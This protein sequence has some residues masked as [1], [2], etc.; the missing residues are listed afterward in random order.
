MLHLPAGYGFSQG[1]EPA[2]RTCLHNLRA[3][4]DA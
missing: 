3:L 2:T 1:G 4:V